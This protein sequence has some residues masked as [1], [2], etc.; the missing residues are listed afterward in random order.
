MSLLG[1]LFKKKLKPAD[2]DFRNPITTEFHS[3]LIPAID[4]GVKTIEESIEI[5]R[6]WSEMGYKKVITTPHIQGDFFKN[7]PHNILPGLELLRKNLKEKNIPIE[8][9]AAAE[10]LLDDVLEQKIETGELLT[11]GDKYILVELPFMEEPRNMKSVLFALRVNGFKPV[12]AHPERYGY[13]SRQ[14]EKFEE[15]F[16]SGILFQ[17]NIFSLVGY[18][19]PEVQKTAEWLIEKKMVNMIGSDTHGVRHLP[20][21]QTAIGSK[22]YQDICGLKLLNNE[23]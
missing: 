17:V 10:Y 13:M 14:K 15:L 12:L 4:D 19:S 16:D 7:G 22:N 5:L 20:V 3:H 6:V 1:N 11:F 9:F 2:A 21:L 23:L 18:Y 8:I